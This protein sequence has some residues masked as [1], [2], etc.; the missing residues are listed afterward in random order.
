[1][2]PTD[3]EARKNWEKFGHPDGK[4]AVDMG[5]ALP[6]WIMGNESNGPLILAALVMVGIVLPLGAA[7]WFLLSSSKFSGPNQ[8]MAQTIEM[9]VR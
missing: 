4:Q 1:M 5:I 6:S 8:V 9:F 2:L 7:A 3:A